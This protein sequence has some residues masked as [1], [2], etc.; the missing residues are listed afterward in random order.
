MRKKSLKVLTKMFALVA[1]I[2]SI[3]IV[4]V[5]IADPC[6]PLFDGDGLPA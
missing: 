1:F 5:A 2:A 4:C 3:F 6:D